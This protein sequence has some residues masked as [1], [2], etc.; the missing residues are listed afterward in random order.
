M[1]TPARCAPTAKRV[2]WG[3]ND[4]GEASPPSG[5]FTSISA[6]AGFTCGLRENGAIECWGVN[7]LNQT[8]VTSPPAGRFTSITTGHYHGCALRESRRSSMLGI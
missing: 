1:I 6:G 8:G 7:N 2:C 3:R 5:R 4:H